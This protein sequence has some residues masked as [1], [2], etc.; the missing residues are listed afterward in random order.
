M[1]K[2]LPFL[3]DFFKITL[4]YLP[5]YARTVLDRLVVDTYKTKGIR[6]STDITKY[7]SNQFP[8]FDDLIAVAKKAKENKRLQEIERDAVIEI[9]DNLLKFD[10][11]NMYGSLWNGY[12]TLSLNNEFTTFNFRS[13]DSSSSDE[14]KNA[15]M[16]LITKFLNREVIKNY[17]LQFKSKEE[18]NK[19]ILLIV[20]EA[21]VFIDPEFPIALDL[22]KNMTK[23]IR[24]YNGSFWVATQ[25]IAD[26]IGFDINTKTKATAVLNNCQYTALFGLKP[27]D[28][29]QVRDMYAKSDVGA[30]TDEEVAYLLNA[31]QGDCL[32]LID[33]THRI[34]FHTGLKDSAKETNLILKPKLTK[35]ETI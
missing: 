8:T 26:F 24:K 31:S 32:L 15:Q 30:F 11:E 23:R 21:H 34:S 4:P 19:R 1:G 9:Y 28:M 10:K 6:N 18:A 29:E 14:I 35:E 33:Q 17:E 5:P 25:N 20:D 13:L 2:H 3:T 27:N 16:L 7:K 22:M 12:T